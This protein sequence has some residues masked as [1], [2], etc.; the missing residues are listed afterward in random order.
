MEKHIQLAPS[1]PCVVCTP[2]KEWQQLRP[3]PLV[4]KVNAASKAA[5]EAAER[6]DSVLIMEVRAQLVG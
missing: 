4:L 1:S 6:G 3:C 2:Q 5:K